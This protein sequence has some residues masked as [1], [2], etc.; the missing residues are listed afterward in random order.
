CDM[1]T[2]QAYCTCSDG[3]TGTYC[4]VDAQAFGNLGGNSSEGLIDVIDTGKT[5]PATVISALP[6]LL[7]FLTDEQR[8]E[9]SYLVE[10][11]IVDAT[12]EEQT[13]DVRESFTFF[14]DPS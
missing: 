13:L 1:D 9:M 7:S 2:S 8:V 12:F 4:A 10:D 3:W 11:M 14:N 5:N 6:A